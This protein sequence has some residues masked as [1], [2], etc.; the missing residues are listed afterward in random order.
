M[1]VTPG[2]QPPATQ[3]SWSLATISP[4]TPGSGPGAMR[5]TRLPAKLVTQI[6][7]VATASTEGGSSGVIVATTW[8]VAGSILVTVPLGPLE[9]QI[10]SNPAVTSRT[11]AW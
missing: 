9:T 3:M 1:W 4:Q 10:E 8:F 2:P 5:I 7:S 6:A 11:V